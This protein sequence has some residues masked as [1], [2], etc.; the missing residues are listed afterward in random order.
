MSNKHVALSGHVRRLC[1]L[2]CDPHLVIPHVT[3][4]LRK[5]AGAEWAMFF[6]A[7]EH[8]GLADV[9]SEN[10]AVLDV[11]PVYFAQIHNTSNQEVLGVDFQTAMRRGRGYENSLQFDDALPGSTMYGELWQPT[12]IR[13]SLELTASDGRRGWGSLQLA[14]P[15]GGSPFTARNHADIRPLSRHIAHA[16]R[17]PEQISVHD[18]ELASSAIVV[19]DETGKV[20]LRS[21]EGSRLLWLAGGAPGLA[22]VEAR[23]PDWL[24][25]LRGTFNRLWQGVAVP[26]AVLERRCA[27]GRF[28]FKAY[29]FDPDETC[30]HGLA[31]AIHI[32]HFPP[33]ALAVE[34]RGFE[35]GLSERQ[36]QICLHMIAGRSYG[37]IARLLDVRESTVIDHVRKLYR[38][39]DV[40]NRGELRGVF[41][42][43]A[44][45]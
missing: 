24:S 7:D 30:V 29:R 6:Y 3:E 14:R 38:K 39:L 36:R 18:A 40:H 5:I 44:S 21:A 23:L 8:F 27:A 11:M 12:G 2:G 28:V 9:Y 15:P 13:H 10:Q 37:E 31:I 43:Q 45:A 34:N 16:L 1:S 35:L 26:P 4:A 17:S 32:E 42:A 22:R 19:A 25:P 20:L 33:L 41:C